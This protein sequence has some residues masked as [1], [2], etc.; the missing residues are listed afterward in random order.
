VVCDQEM[1]NQD[2]ALAYISTAVAWITFMPWLVCALTTSRHHCNCQPLSTIIIHIHQHD[3]QHQHL[4]STGC[5]FRSCPSRE[6]RGSSKMML[7]ARDNRAKKITNLTPSLYGANLESWSRVN[8]RVHIHQH[9]TKPLRP[10]IG[11]G[12][13][14]KSWSRVTPGRC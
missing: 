3:H 7:R 14:L 2:S 9:I 10:A 13:N 4:G 12:A 8:K 6:L 5:W 1:A 11:F